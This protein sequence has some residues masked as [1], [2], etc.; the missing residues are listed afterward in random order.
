MKKLN[1]AMLLLIGGISVIGLTGCEQVEQAANDAV[2]K[3]KQTAVQALAEA[4]QTGSIDQGKQSA[5]QTLLDAKQKAAG[6][7]GQAS[8]YLSEDQ[9]EQEVGI[10]SEQDT[11]AAI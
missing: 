9:Q 8:E 3:A 2:K 4:T 10:A 7:L 5:N 1:P 11:A 6:L